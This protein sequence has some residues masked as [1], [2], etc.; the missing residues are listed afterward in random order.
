MRQTRARKNT[1]VIHRCYSL[2]SDE[3]MQPHKGAESVC[4]LKFQVCGVSR[5][6]SNACTRFARLR[7]DGKIRIEL[8]YERRSSVGT[9]RV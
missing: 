1:T 2:E 4:I 9:Q 7:S 3:Y 5:S 8:R 6:P